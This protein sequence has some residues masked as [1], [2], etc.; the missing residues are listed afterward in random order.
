[1]KKRARLL[2]TLPAKK[3]AK[4]EGLAFLGREQLFPGHPPD[5]FICVDIRHTK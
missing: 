1:M 2:Y 3:G 5:F 4:R